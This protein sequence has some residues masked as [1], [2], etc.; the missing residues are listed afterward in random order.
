MPALAMG[1][2][3]VL[4]FAT[5][6]AIALSALVAG[7]EYGEKVMTSESNQDSCSLPKSDEELRRLLTPEQY[8]IIRENGTE[9]PFANEYW[10]NKKEGLY[11]DRVSG[12]PLFS[13]RDKYDSGTG[14]P[15][16]TRPVQGA[17]VAVKPDRSHGTLRTEIRSGRGDSHLGH[18]FDDGPAPGGLR[19]CVNSA[20]LRFVPLAELE[21]Q[22]Y[23]LFRSHFEA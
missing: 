15:S 19:Y 18:V 9:R 3:Q 14:W 2:K 8:H 21:A 5:G 6:I 17:D 4:L 12:E 20:A 11:V 10:N 1:I 7:A 16:F 13:S 23:G 22:G